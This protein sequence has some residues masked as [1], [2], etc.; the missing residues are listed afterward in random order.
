MPN[1]EHA[2][3]HGVQALPSE[4]VI[5]GAI[6]E[7]RLQELSSADQ[8]MLHGSDARDRRIAVHALAYRQT[9]AS[10]LCRGRE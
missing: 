6:A 9:A 3:V 1:Q 4:T 5:D 7:S 10:S 8:A 2:P